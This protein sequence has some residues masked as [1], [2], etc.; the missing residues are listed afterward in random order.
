MRTDIENKETRYTIN[1]ELYNLI[2]DYNPCDMTIYEYI[3]QR[4]VLQ[5]EIVDTSSTTTS[6]RNTTSNIT[7]SLIDSESQYLQSLLQLYP[8]SWNTNSDIL[9]RHVLIAYNNFINTQTFCLSII[10][11]SKKYK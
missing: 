2:V 11:R 1:K 5:M 9:I 7:M 10:T 4:F 3:L 8:N 6:I